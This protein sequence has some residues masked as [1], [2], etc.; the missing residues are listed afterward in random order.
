MELADQTGRTFVVTGA[1]SGLG[2]AMTRHLAARGGR[3]IMAV[4]DVAK[5]DRVR[6]GLGA[7]VE[8]RHLDLLDL[9]TVRAFAE[10]MRA[11]G[12]TV[13]ALINNGGISGV[14]RRLSPQGVESQLA[15]NHLGHFA[16]TGLLLDGLA[17]GRHPVVVTVGSGLYRIGRLD[18]ADLAAEQRYSPGGAYAASKLANVL[19]ALELDRRLRAAGSPVRSLLAHPGMAKTDLGR[20]SSPFTRAVGA[21]LGAF[22]RL[23]IDDAVTPMLHAATDPTAPTGRNIGPGKG[24]LRFD[25]LGGAATDRD[26]ARRLWEVSE[27]ITGVAVHR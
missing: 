19:F 10:K 15:T 26:L 21:L 11:D 16:L 4:R 27:Q 7:N 20:E 18:L 25:R 13:D 17:A 14:P 9:D 3:V 12:I 1:S 5:A 24:R 2:A 23:P 8:A 6:H 22:M